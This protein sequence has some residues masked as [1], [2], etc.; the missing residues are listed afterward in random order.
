ML[1]LK[2]PHITLE[3]TSEK[4]ITNLKSQKT[5]VREHITFVSFFQ[6]WKR[7]HLPSS[8]HDSY[9]PFLCLLWF[10]ID[11]KL[12]SIF[13]RQTIMIIA[14]FVDMINGSTSSSNFLLERMN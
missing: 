7:N 1:E 14:V 5:Q 9:N 10:L 12:L 4:D 8:I 11:T 3:T 6:N 2:S 13:Q